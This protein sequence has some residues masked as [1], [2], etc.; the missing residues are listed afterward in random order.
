MKRASLSPMAQAD[1]D[2]IAYRIALD[3]PSAAERWVRLLGERFQL[4]A[5]WPGSGPRRPEFGAKLRS[6]PFGNYV[7]FYE[8]AGDGIAVLRVLDGHRDL[9]RM[10]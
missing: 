1:V 7:I 2:E 6:Y 4:L 5:D 3:K 8:E 10:F 9:R